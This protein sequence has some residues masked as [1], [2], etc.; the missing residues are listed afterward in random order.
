MAALD[1]AIDL[2]RLARRRSRNERVRV[3][4]AFDGRI[5]E[6]SRVRD[7]GAPAAIHHGAGIGRP[8]Q[9]EVYISAQDAEAF[10]FAR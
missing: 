4:P 6:D 1:E 2:A 8:E 10:R 3:L 5:V 9:R 7:G